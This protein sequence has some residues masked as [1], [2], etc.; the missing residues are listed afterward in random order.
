MLIRP[1]GFFTPQPED[2]GSYLL[3]DY[4]GAIAAW[5]ICRK[6]KTDYSGNCIRVSKD[7][8]STI[9]SEQDIGFDGDGNLDLSALTTFI[10]SDYGRVVKV[11]D[12]SGNGNDLELAWPHSGIT[13]TVADDPTIINAGTTYEVNDK[14]A[15]SNPSD[16]TMWQTKDPIQDAVVWHFS[17]QRYDDP[18]T[19][20][21][22]YPYAARV[23]MGNTNQYY[24]K[25][26]T[27][28]SV[29][30]SD[31][32]SSLSVYKNGGSSIA[33]LSINSMGDTFVTS[34]QTLCVVGDL[35]FTDVK[36]DDGMQ[37]RGWNQDYGPNIFYFQEHIFWNSDQAANRAGISDNI[38]TYYAI[39]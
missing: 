5:S 10:G 3:D 28:A 34:E 30:Y 35:D 23:D 18:Q 21:V 4:P 38:N 37:I 13:P 7:D 2:S 14:P 8:N 16:V 11:Y 9:D 1:M 20:V 19:P 39:Y 27:G 15:V 31:V 12:Q 6:L 29:S 22:V 17:V 36:W 26:K 25:V 24:M 33:D 32:G